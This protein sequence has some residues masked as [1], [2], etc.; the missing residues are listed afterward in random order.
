MLK[1]LHTL[2]IPG[3]TVSG[4]TWELNS[5]RIALA[6]D[7][8]IYFANIRHDYKVTLHS[9]CLT[10]VYTCVFVYVCSVCVLYMCVL[11]VCRVYACVGVS[12]YV[13]VCVYACLCV[14][15]CMC[16]CLCLCLSVSVRVQ[17]NMD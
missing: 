11:H 17:S 13:C 8:Y 2:R 10:S 14:C 3:K 1:H 12:M 7:S 5:L 6:V 15:V 16:L 4:I 9:V